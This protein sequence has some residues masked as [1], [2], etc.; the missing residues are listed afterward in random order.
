MGAVLSSA[1]NLTA[2]VGSPHDL[3]CARHL[4]GHM[5]LNSFGSLSHLIG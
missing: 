1:P 5:D 2:G 4:L 3:L